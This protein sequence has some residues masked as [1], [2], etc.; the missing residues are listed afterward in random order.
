MQQVFVE[1]TEIQTAGEWEFK[2]DERI[3]SEIL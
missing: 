1:S 3:G 2:T